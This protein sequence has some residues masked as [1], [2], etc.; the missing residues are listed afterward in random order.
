MQHGPEV[1]FDMG[2]GLIERWTRREGDVAAMSVA[3]VDS[4]GVVKYWARADDNR[5]T[6]WAPVP[7][8]PDG[9]PP[10]GQPPV[11]QAPA[12]NSRAEANFDGAHDRRH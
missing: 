4:D 9:Q 2:C 5:G 8:A 6:P 11:A 10:D 7:L 1:D 3:E 12:A